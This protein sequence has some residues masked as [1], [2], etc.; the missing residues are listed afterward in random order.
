MYCNQCGSKMDD[1]QR[2]CTKCGARLN[3]TGTPTAAQSNFRSVYGRS[4]NAHVIVA[5]GFVSF[6]LA[7]IMMLTSLFKAGMWGLSTPVDIF[8]VLEIEYLRWIIM[9]CYVISAVMLILFVVNR[10]KQSAM[11]ILPAMIVSGAVFVAILVVLFAAQDELGGYGAELSLSGSGV[12]C[13]IMSIMT[14][15]LLIVALFNLKSSKIKRMI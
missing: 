14:A 7:G 15:F 9:I 2:F 5:I 6:V 13:L 3:N 1:N 12:F 8:E 10:N 4:S 11:F